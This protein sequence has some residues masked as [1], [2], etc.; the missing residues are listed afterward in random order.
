MHSVRAGRSPASSSC[1]LLD[2]EKPDGIAHAG[3]HPSVSCVR[4]RMRDRRWQPKTVAF[5]MTKTK[6]SSV[7]Y[8]CLLQQYKQITK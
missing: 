6:L 7:H 8:R 1:N 5:F 4:A 2:A 3:I